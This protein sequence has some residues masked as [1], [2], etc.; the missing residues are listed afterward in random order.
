MI[1]L[2]NLL[3]NMLDPTLQKQLNHRVATLVANKLWLRE[4]CFGIEDKLHKATQE[5]AAQFIL[6]PQYTDKLFILTLMT[7]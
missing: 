6:Q 4:F 3:I 1:L 7:F 5:A 2:K